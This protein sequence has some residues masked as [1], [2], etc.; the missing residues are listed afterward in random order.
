M[1]PTLVVLL[2]S[3]L[4]AAVAG[5]GA[6]PLL[7]RERVPTRWV[8]WANATAA[9][10]MLG[11]A[12]ALASAVDGA[13]LASAVGALVGVLYSAWTHRVLGTEDLELNRL[14]EIDAVYGY[15]I[16][17]VNTLHSASEGVAIGVAMAV[18]LPFGAFLAV[19]I[20]VH[21]I[22]EAVVLCEVLRGR[23]LR[24][25]QAA[26]LAVATNLSQVLLSVVVFAVVGAAPAMLPGALGFAVGALIYLVLV[27]LLPES[28][29]EAGPTTIAIVT[30]VVMGVVVLLRG[31]LG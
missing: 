22:P 26:G 21:N 13:P 12:W 20:G 18:H 11:A 10:L 24:P 6:L 3:S 8:G 19:A 25:G 16:L 5:L 15:Q 31:A 23:G 30:T 27:E 29:R 7:R 28:Y 14:S 17:L 9:G 4:A 1:E 2:Y